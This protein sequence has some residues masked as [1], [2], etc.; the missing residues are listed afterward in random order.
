LR[1]KGGCIIDC[2]PIKSKSISRPFLVILS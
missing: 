1:S 2:D